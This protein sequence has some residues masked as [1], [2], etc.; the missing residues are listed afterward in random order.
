MSDADFEHPTYQAFFVQKPSSAD[1][2]NAGFDPDKRT[3]YTKGNKKKN[4]AQASRAKAQVNPDRLL[5]NLTVSDG[6]NTDKTRIVFNDRQQMDYEM[7]CDAVKFASTEN[8]PQ[9]YSTYKNVNYAINERPNGNREVQLGFSTKKNGEFSIAAVRM[10]TPLLLKDT[11]L[12]ITFDLGVG[13]YTF[14]AKAGTY[15][16]RFVLTPAA[17]DDATAISNVNADAASNA[18]D[19]SGRRTE[20]AQKGVQIVN[21]KKML[22]K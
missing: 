11:E 22:V 4:Q 17:T 15:D 19:L 1:L 16:N 8:V 9:L 3:T 5:V 10:D 6:E 21:G 2:R 7:E 13:E 20:K 14:T 12:D 18:Y